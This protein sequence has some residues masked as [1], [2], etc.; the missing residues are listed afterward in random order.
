MNPVPPKPAS[1]KVRWE[2]FLPDELLERIRQHPVCYCAYGLAEPHGVYNALGL[3]WLKAQALCERAAAEHGGVVAP[4]F[5][6]HVAERPFFDWLGSQ[7]V[8]Q[9]LCSSIPEDLFLRMVLYQLRAIDARGFHAALL[10]TGHYGGLENDLRLLVAYYLRRT[11]SPLRVYAAADWEVIQYGDIRGDHAG[12]CETS[13]LLALR[14]ELVDLQRREADS[15]SGPWAGVDF[16]PQQRPSAELGGKIVD[17]Q[18]R[19][20]GAIS[21][22]LLDGYRDVADW[23]TP[24][25]TDAE[26]LW[27]RFERLT[28]KYWWCSLTL[29]QFLAGQRVPFPGW[30]ALGE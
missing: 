13:Q 17:S 8:T 2:E 9:A 7:G 27:L 5:A 19:R 14:P 10:I 15:R 12:I 11:G 6:W 24:T 20:L 16:D 23:R 28:R 3:D 26:D 18:V 21:R 4:P 1:A 29:E 25:L 30:E 22:E